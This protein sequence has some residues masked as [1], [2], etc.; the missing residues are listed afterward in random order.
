MEYNSATGSY[1]SEFLEPILGAN[2]K[3]GVPYK[4]DR[5]IYEN[6]FKKFNKDI[7][8]KDADVVVFHAD[9]NK[10]YGDE[11][12]GIYYY[13][14]FAWPKNSPE[15]SEGLYD[16]SQFYDRDYDNKHKEAFEDFVHA[17]LKSIIAPDEEY[18]KKLIAEL[19]QEVDTK[20]KNIE[21]LKNLL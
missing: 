10:D 2:F 21:S 5:E 15:E 9:Y 11:E 8:I 14:F 12:R 4:I 19:Q 7:R 18:T 16:C 13:A 17:V 1:E 3:Y 20:I 6:A